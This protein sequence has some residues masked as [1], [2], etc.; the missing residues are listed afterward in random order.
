MIS[1]GASIVG[2]AA[3]LALVAGPAAADAGTAVDRAALFD[4]LVDRTMQRG[5][6][7]DFKMRALDYD[8]RASMM[9]VRDEFLAADTDAA[10][11]YALVKLSNARHDRHLSVRPAQGGIAVPDDPGVA[12]PVRFHTDYATPGAYF[13]FV[14]DVARDIAAL[15]SGGRVPRIGDRLV[16]VNGQPADA[17]IAA[18][19]PYHR[20]S[21]V[22]GFWQR[23]A[24]TVHEK[25]RFVAP[26][27]YRADFTVTLQGADGRSYDLTVPYLPADQIDWAGHDARRYDGFELVEKRTTFDLYRHGG[28]RDVLIIAWHRFGHRLIEDMDWLMATAAEN[29]WLDH[30]IIW[31][32]TRSGGGSKGVYALQRLSPTPFKTTFGNLRI[33]DI[34]DDFVAAKVADIDTD[35]ARDSGVTETVDAGQW[36]KDWLINDVTNAIR[37][38]QAYTNN[39]PF[40]SAHLPKWSDGIARP[41]DVHFTGRMVCLFLPN[42]GSHLDQFAAM[43]VDNK[44]CHAIGMPAG[45]YSNTWEWTEAVRFPISGRPVVRFMWN[46]GHTIRPNGQVLEGNPADVDEY[47]P[48]TRDNFADYYDILLTRAYNTFAQP[49]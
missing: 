22:N 28:G 16:A 43:V 27:L 9:A 38:G 18:L 14:S 1:R 31:D 21:S 45:G 12:A 2:L 6:F 11:Y 41:A 33:S 39:V 42:G 37:A 3:S 48:V 10:L 23:M 36:L 29:G 25:K 13:L 5:A 34:T 20:Y 44:L 46:I 15:S 17:Y 49:K 24:P 47:I 35:A 32:G 19:R 40:K 26:S 4:Y 30:D 8:V 7:S